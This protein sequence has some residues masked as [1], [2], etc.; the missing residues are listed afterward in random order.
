M[1]GRFAERLR[2]RVILHGVT[3]FDLLAYKFRVENGV[4]GEH[5]VPAHHSFV[6][7]KR[8]EHMFEAVALHI[9]RHRALCPKRRGGAVAG[10]TFG[11][12]VVRMAVATAPV[13]C[14]DSAPTVRAVVW[15]FGGPLAA[16]RFDDS[17]QSDSAVE[18]RVLATVPYV[19]ALRLVDDRF[20]LAA[21][22]S[23]IERGLRDRITAV[24]ERL[25]ASDDLAVSVC[26]PTTVTD[27]YRYSTERIQY[28]IVTMNHQ[29]INQ[30]FLQPSE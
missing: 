25:A 21:P 27:A 14:D 24:D 1:R 4:Y 23:F 16:T 5:D 13:W 11:L 30:E 29:S 6:T 26:H 2:L 22:A 9:P 3:E 20:M 8:L 15:Y 17:R 12:L 18:R 19:R 28:A 7:L 10:L